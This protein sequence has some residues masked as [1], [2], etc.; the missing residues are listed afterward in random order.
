MLME[1]ITLTIMNDK[2]LEIYELRHIRIASE[3]IEKYP[4]LYDNYCEFIFCIACYMGDTNFVHYLVDNYDINFRIDNDLFFRLLCDNADSNIDLID[5]FMDKYPDIDVSFDNEY[6]F[7]VACKIGFLN[8]IKRLSN[9][10]EINVHESNELPFQKACEYGHYEVVKYLLKKYPDIDIHADKE[11]ALHNTCTYGYLDILKLL[12]KR[13][14]NIHIMNENPIKK[15]CRYGQL[16][17]IKY[18]LHEYNDIDIRNNDDL[19]FYLACREDHLD[20]IKYLLKKFPK[21]DVHANDDKILCIA[22]KNGHLEVVKYLVNNYNFD[23]Y[24]ISHAIR[25][26]CNHN[27]TCSHNYYEIVRLLKYTHPFVDISNIWI[28]TNYSEEIYH[29]MINN[30][31]G[32]IKRA[33]K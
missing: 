14:A 17:I 6:I 24:I 18:L 11:L 32:L 8:F 23:A 16:E 28:G 21:I 3:M 20:V 27:N 33:N 26:C 19:A 1:N 25:L 12:L 22:C 29:F 4:I 31:S 5:Y 15:A 7:R 2:L 13:G 9:S 10:Y 30:Q